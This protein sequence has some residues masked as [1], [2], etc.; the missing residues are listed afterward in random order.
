[1][2]N[3]AY[4]NPSYNARYGY[5]SITK[6]SVISFVRRCIE[7]RN[8]NLGA[9]KAAYPPT[10]K[11]GK[12]DPFGL[13]GNSDSFFEK[14]KRLLEETDGGTESTERV[15]D[16]YLPDVSSY[17][18]RM[19][20]GDMNP[21]FF[22][23]ILFLASEKYP[24]RVASRINSFGPTTV[25]EV[26]LSVKECEACTNVKDMKRCLSLTISRLRS[27]MILGLDVLNETYMCTIM[28]TIFQHAVLRAAK[29]K[30]WSVE[31]A[32]AICCTG[33]HVMTSFF[34]HGGSPHLPPLLKNDG[35]PCKE[36]E[37]TS[38]RP[39]CHVNYLSKGSKEAKEM[40]KGCS[41]REMLCSAYSGYV[42]SV[43]LFDRLAHLLNDT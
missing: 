12:Y 8:Y 3:G 9:L 24:K 28:E 11:L 27:F 25:A 29:P 17:F 7:E 13:R 37:C 34:H 10:K 5:H 21:E 22:I 41:K 15:G 30:V 6:A 42:K 20:A 2:E 40:C 31:I 38:H 19:L 1:M 4:T 18:V 14:V 16:F 43:T 36:F 39:V 23:A 32:S 26:I 33:K 35:T